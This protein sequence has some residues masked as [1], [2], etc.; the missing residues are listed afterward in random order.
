MNI[1]EQKTEAM[2]SIR[3][4]V[5][6]MVSSKTEA[7]FTILKEGLEAPSGGF[8]KKQQEVAAR[9]LDSLQQQLMQSL[10]KDENALESAIETLDT[11][12]KAVDIIYSQCE[13]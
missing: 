3:N 10:D 7:V 9:T 2:N 8:S 11:C 6:A 4:V 12:I 5:K 13:D 1:N